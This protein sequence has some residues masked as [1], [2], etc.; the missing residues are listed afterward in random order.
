MSRD[1]RRLQWR[2]SSA[3]ASSHCVEVAAQGDRI[4]VRNTEDPS[5]EVLVFTEAE[6]DAFVAGVGRG[7]FALA[8]LRS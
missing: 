2:T 3:C 4:F 5:G 8:T 7:E 6:W 1:L